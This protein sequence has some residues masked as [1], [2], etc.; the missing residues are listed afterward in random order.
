MLRNGI[1]L[2]GLLLSEPNDGK[3]LNKVIIDLKETFKILEK[4]QKYLW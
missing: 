4:L 2:P 1:V 3:A